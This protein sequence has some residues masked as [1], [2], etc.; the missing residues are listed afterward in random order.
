MKVM[1]MTKRNSKFDE[2]DKM[3]E[4]LQ[5]ENNE[6]VDSLKE[7]LYGKDDLL[8]F[9]E[10]ES[11]DRRVMIVH[12][13]SLP[14]VPSA[15]KS[16][17]DIYLYCLKNVDYGSGNNRMYVDGH[18]EALNRYLEQAKLNPTNL[19]VVLG[20]VTDEMRR[21]GGTSKVDLKEK[22]YYDGLSYVNQALKK[23]KDIVAKD[24]NDTLRK[25]LGR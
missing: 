14:A 11:T 20:T 4:E 1:K 12:R 16:R 13:P 3:F 5:K 15:I 2:I 22:G 6:T 10:K 25:E 17:L 19:E 18:I 8:S 23:S 24:I 7:R 9:H 21:L